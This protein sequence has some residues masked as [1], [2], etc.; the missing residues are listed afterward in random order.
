MSWSIKILSPVVNK[1]TDTT[2]GRVRNKGLT[3][4]AGAGDKVETNQVEDPAHYRSLIRLS[5]KIEGLKATIL[6]D[7]GA[8]GNFIDEDFVRR[9]GL[10][11]ELISSDRSSEVTLADGSK[12]RIRERVKNASIEVAPSYK[13]KASF[14]VMSL[15]GYE[16]I[17]GMPWLSRANPSIHWPSGTISVMS[18]DGRSIVLCTET[19]SQSKGQEEQKEESKQCRLINDQ[20]IP[21]PEA[22][23]KFIALQKDEQVM[24]VAWL[25]PQSESQ[26]Q[27]DAE[28]PAAEKIVSEFKDVFPEELPKGLPPKRDVDHEIV[29][30]PGVK[31][32]SRAPYRMSVKEL[33]ELKE[34]L[35][36]NLKHGFIRPSRSPFGSPVLFVKKKDGSMRLCV[37]YRALNKI[38]V[39][40]K[41]PLPLI[42]DLLDQLQGAK[43]FS[44]IDLRSGYHQIRIAENDISKTAFRTRYGHFEFLVLPFGLTNAPATFMHLI[45]KIFHSYLDRFVVVYLDDIL[46]YSRSRD[47]HEEHLRTVLQ[48]LRENK[49]YAKLNKCAFYRTE[50]EFLGHVISA[51][52]VYMEKNKMQDIKGWPQPKSVHEVRS[53]LGLAGFYRKFIKNFSQISS[54]MTDLLKKDSKFKWTERHQEAFESLKKAVS[55]APV[56]IIPDPKLPFVVSTDASGYAIGATLSQDQGRGLQPVSFL[57]KKMLP[58]E[59]NYP[60]HEQELLAII[61]ALKEWR[62][63]LHGNKVKVITDHKSLKYLESQPHLSPRQVRWS[64]F[65]QQFDMEI[66]YQQGK[67]NV[68][69]DA[70]SRR[71][72]HANDQMLVNSGIS[73]VNWGDALLQQIKEG[74]QQDEE[75]RRMLSMERTQDTDFTILN[76]LIYKNNNVYIPNVLQIKTQLLNEAHDAAISGHVGM[77]KTLE[78]LSRNYYWPKMKE[79]VTHYVKSCY[80]CQSNKPNNRYPLGLLQSIP[81]PEKAW[82]QVSMDLITQLPKTKEGYDAI[83]VFVDKF[84]KMVHIAP[85]T[86]TVTAPQLARIFFREVVRLHGVPKSIISDRDPRFT[87][88]FWKC[89]WSQLGTKLAMSTAYHPQ[90]DGQTERTNRTIED[91]LRAYVNY[92]Q[93]DW[94][95]HLIAAEI[96]INNSQQTSTGFSPY[97]LN[98]HQHPNLPL[99]GIVAPK[100]KISQ[101][102]NPAAGEALDG[103]K[104]LLQEARVNLEEASRRQAY[105]ANQ[106]RRDHQFKVG[107]LVWL[108]SKDFNL[109]GRTP[110]FAPRNYGPFEVI[111]RI[112]EVAYKLKLPE[113]WK[114]HPVFHISKLKPNNDELQHFPDRHREVTRPPPVLQE[115]ENQQEY[116]VDRIVGVRTRKKGKKAIKEYLVL[117]KGYPEWERTWE[118]DNNLQNAQQAISDFE[119][120]QH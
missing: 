91:M 72:D 102:K 80:K 8:S 3:V 73:T 15:N 40:N 12:K 60:V 107:D 33:E 67:S 110:K 34:Q 109:E 93:N 59:C 69:A 108:S 63:Y 50:I 68:V 56:L 14:T 113:Q 29:L 13:F 22:P 62:H 49:L 9:N 45:Q 6:V 106:K 81:V 57:S 23:E 36:E 70:L 52:G 112:G 39:K 51:D 66:E 101:S 21:R 120:S 37:D 7:C 103:F 35:D 47:E 115:N 75:C 48:V 10:V 25:Q 104:K 30:M 95:K 2:E 5:T 116:E 86:T 26:S 97:Y 42:S 99:S 84:T 82:E 54:A 44:K 64:E 87:S 20:E 119:T 38:T 4:K 55:S 27:S 79:D 78:L 85:T 77:S 74:Y 31:P 32:P 88:N 58:A 18:E 28:L 41:Y 24:C 98:Y 118:S 100:S 53:F 92:K 83:V 117:W 17:L 111:Q 96:T 90:T 71:V 89:L 19:S 65:L 61:C 105:Y 11:T 76:G 1:K 43:I 94:N 114:I 16:A 46:V